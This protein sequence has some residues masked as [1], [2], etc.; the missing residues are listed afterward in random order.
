MLNPID[1]MLTVL[2]V[3]VCAALATY[4]FLEWGRSTKL[5]GYTQ[6]MQ[7]C[8][9]ALTSLP[10]GWLADRPW[11]G[12]SKVLKIIS[13]FYI[14]A[15]ACTVTAVLL[16][17][18]T[19]H[20]PYLTTDS[21][22]LVLCCACILWGSAQAAGPVVESLLADS[23]PTGNRSQLYSYLFS[24][25]ILSMS[26]GPLI[27]AI[28][29]WVT[30]NSWDVTSLERV[31]LI[32]MAAALVPALVLLQFD[33]RKALG[34]ESDAVKQPLLP[35]GAG[36][37]AAEL[38]GQALLMKPGSRRCA[39]LS[40]AS[41]PYI[42]AVSDFITG[43][44]SGMTIRFMPIFLLQ[45][46]NLSPIAVNFVLAGTPLVLAL[47]SVLGSPVSRLLGRVQTILFLKFSGVAL[48][49]ILGLHPG[50]WRH[51]WLVI[52]IYCVRTS[53]INASYP[54][55]KSILMDFVPKEKRGMW[56]SFESL[57]VLGWSGSAVFGGIMLERGFAFT[58]S[59]TALLQIGRKSQC[60]NDDK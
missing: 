32:G 43:V 5:V 2:H 20:L 17:P 24:T 6:G 47:C 34:H 54:L 55:Q 16:Q 29:F 46:V 60:L 28:V 39:C 49:A 53:L 8:A 50:L 58:F 51:P 25:L 15:I 38:G 44:A 21:K 59:T 10:L 7:G 30:G 22:Y 33:D 26:C 19:I 23:V 13:S 52:P 11:M 57:F 41:V 42:M 4:I 56:N 40:T 1:A 3:A 35:Q 9:V 12:R 37:D 48:L 45:E 31:I 18:E 14:C 27:S 36:D